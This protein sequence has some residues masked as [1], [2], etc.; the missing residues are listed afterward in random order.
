MRILVICSRIPYPL[1][2]GGAI[3]T[4]EMIKGLAQSGNEV[5]VISL[6]TK[7]HFVSNNIVEQEFDFCQKIETFDIDTNIKITK[8]F[9]NL[10]SNK[11]YNLSRF[12][13]LEFLE[14]LQ[15]EVNANTYDI[16]QFEG[17][18]V[19]EYAA[20]LVA[21][22]PKILRQHNVE[23][24]IWERLA[25]N[26][27]NKVKALYLGILSRRMKQFEL[28]VFSSF[29]GIIAISEIDA[30]FFRDYFSENI[31]T[32]PI[33][34]K[35][36]RLKF[37]ENFNVYHIGSM[38]WLPNKE[39]VK[40][41]LNKV[42]DKVLKEIPH[43]HFYVAGKGIIA[44]DYGK[45]NNV[46]ICGE[47]ESLKKFTSDKK[48]LIVPLLSGGGI[49]VKIIEAMANGKLIASTT[50]GVQGLNDG[51]KI[52][53]TDEPSE[54]AHNIIELLN[55]KQTESIVESNYEYVESNFNQFTLSE[56]LN[57]Y[58]SSLK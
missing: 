51:F 52:S 42:W 23:H 37:I 32:I 53:V 5:S 40:W 20:K 54:F 35:T 12:W 45:Y 2:D 38:E 21:K 10:F 48:L 34:V 29:D 28:S 26:E 15:R 6:N 3:A 44:S 24:Q 13:N 36:E 9:I 49:R 55:S 14:L 11:S 27:K 7:K 30:S 33:A 16:I 58:Y 57:Q 50:Q 39:G 25:K 19:A 56:K 8:A 47:V 31:L 22:T 1:K 43:A 17:L 46:T 18:F 41:F 4:Y